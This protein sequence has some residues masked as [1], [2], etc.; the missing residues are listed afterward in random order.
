VLPKF[1]NGVGQPEF[2]LRAPL[3][4]FSLG[5]HLHTKTS[6]RTIVSVVSGTKLTNAQLGRTKAH[7]LA[8]S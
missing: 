1:S 6:S 7:F 2:R 3:L 5:L 8:S 4:S